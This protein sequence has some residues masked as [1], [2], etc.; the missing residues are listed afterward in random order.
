MN[1]TTS[2][3]IR[4]ALAVVLLAVAVGIFV[5][6]RGDAASADDITLQGSDTP[7][8]QT[9]TPSIANPAPTPANAT[10]APAP[11]SAGLVRATADAPGLY[12]GTRNAAN[13]NTSALVTALQA[14]GSRARAWAEPLEIAPPDIASYVA[15]LTPVIT[16]VDTRVTDYGFGGGKAVARQMILQAGTD[17][18][19][20]RAGTPRVRCSSGNP[21]GPPRAITGTPSYEGPRWAGFSPATVVII[22]PAPAPVIF[23][24]VD[25][26]TLAV[27]VRIPGGVVIVDIDRPAAG[28]GL[29]VFE[30]GQPALLSGRNWPPGTAVTVTFDN[31]AVTLAT[32][33]ADAAGNLAAPVTIP[34]AATPG[35]HAVTFTGGGFAVNQTIY[36]VPTAPARRL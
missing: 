30:A 24:L 2:R 7:G 16:R 9:F 27:F 11:S 25:V 17:V 21:L 4:L 12:G 14:D 1:S 32:V 18:L 26:N 8:T 36:V 6:R 35:P 28:V 20:D 13:C 23:V 22:A 10:T 31:P 15:T 34:A 5:A 33:N 19:V 29:L 3:N